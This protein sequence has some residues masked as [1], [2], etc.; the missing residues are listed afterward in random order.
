[1][2]HIDF[3]AGALPVASV[4]AAAAT[5]PNTRFV[6]LHGAATQPN[7]SIVD[8]QTPEQITAAVN[9]IVTKAIP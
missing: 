4:N 1:V 9:R 5:F 3:T 2:A 6:V 8:G 7:V